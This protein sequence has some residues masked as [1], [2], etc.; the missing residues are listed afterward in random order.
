MND[1]TLILEVDGRTHR[2]AV[3]RGT[4][5]LH[6]LRGDLGLNGP[7]YGCG[8]GECGACTVMLDGVPARAWNTCAGRASHSAL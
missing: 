5:L 3:P 8:E 6:V 1:E 7:K 4:S 2:L